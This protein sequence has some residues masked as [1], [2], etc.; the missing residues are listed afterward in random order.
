MKSLFRTEIE[1]ICE[2]HGLKMDAD[3]G[4]IKL[5]QP[6]YVPLVIQKVTKDQLNVFHWLDDNR[7]DPLVQLD[8]SGSTWEPI[9]ISMLLY[10]G[11]RTIQPGSFKAFMRDTWAPGI[12]WQRWIDADAEVWLPDPK[13]GYLIKTD[14]SIIEQPKNRFSLKEMYELIDCTSVEAIYPLGPR[15]TTDYVA[16][17]WIMF[18]DEESKLIN[19]PVVNW[20][21]SQLWN[22][23]HQHDVICGNV[24]FFH[25]GE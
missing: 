10:G 24:L 7:Y 13:K 21:A 17:G 9:L 20:T 19:E 6:G 18:G 25:E 14:G 4:Q 2:K 1:A 3:Y 23:P 5:T 15:G 16:N 12:Q 11:R 22:M 8:I